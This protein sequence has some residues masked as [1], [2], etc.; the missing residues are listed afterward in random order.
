[1]DLAWRQVAEA[2]REALGLLGYPIAPA[3]LPHE[4]Q[5]CGGGYAGHAAAHLAALNAV[6]DHQLHHLGYSPAIHDQVQEKVRAELAGCTNDQA[7]PPG[8]CPVTGQAG[9]APGVVKVRLSGQLAD[10]N[11]IAAL[12]ADSGAELVDRSG[13][14]PGHYDPGV[15]V[16]LTVRAP[17]SSSE[18]EPP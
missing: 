9:Q 18:G 2:A 16:Y 11:Q 8:R 10:I 4:A 6:A 17:A 13:P 5:P 7:P 1:M 15:R 14:R 12:L 3:C